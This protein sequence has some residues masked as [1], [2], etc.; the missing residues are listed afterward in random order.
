VLFD[1]APQLEGRKRWRVY[2]GV[3]LAREYSPADFDEAQLTDALLD[4]WSVSFQI[5]THFQYQ[6]ALNIP[7]KFPQAGGGRHAL[8]PSRQHSLRCHVP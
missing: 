1:G 6:S 4:D 5:Q 2:A 3:D 7:S 8:L